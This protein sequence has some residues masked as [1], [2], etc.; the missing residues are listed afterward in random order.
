MEPLTMKRELFLLL[1]DCGAARCGVADLSGV[2]ETALPPAKGPAMCIGVA[3][4]MNLPPATVKEL[5][6]APNMEY[7]RV[8]REYND[9]LV[10]AAHAGAAYLK[11]L[12][13]E[14][15]AQDFDYAKPDE[16][17]TTLLPHKTVAAKAGLGWIGR[18]CLLVTPE[19]GGAVRLG[20]IVTNAPLPADQPVA[21]SRCG[22][23]HL[24]V[25]KCPAH[26]I[27]GNLWEPGLERDRLVDHRRCEAAMYDIME[28]STGER[29][30]FCGKCFAVCPYT[31]KYLSR[32]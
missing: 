13:F 14:A 28:K 17:N 19:F 7:V 29:L 21:Q 15:V 20:S 32:A 22:G 6:E 9:R 4:C 16:N 26:A 18:N 5:I 24:C 12:G 31:R 8:Y 3:F 11:S 30:D 27:Q 10:E 25:D 2:P 1:E 23:C